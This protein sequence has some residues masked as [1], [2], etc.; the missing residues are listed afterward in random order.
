MKFNAKSLVLSTIVSIVI[1]KIYEKIFIHVDHDKKVF[2]EAL[3]FVGSV[4]LVLN[5]REVKI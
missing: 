1:S 4:L 5:I 3:I 2:H